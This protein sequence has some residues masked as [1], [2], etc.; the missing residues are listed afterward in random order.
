MLSSV[1]VLIRM[2][3]TYTFEAE[4]PQSIAT[5]ITLIFS[6]VRSL[7]NITSQA[8]GLKQSPELILYVVSL[9]QDERS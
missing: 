1:K 9:T 3:L 5:V 7:E 6:W 8:P 2:P 4:C